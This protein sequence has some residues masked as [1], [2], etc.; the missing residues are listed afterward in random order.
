MFY[1]ISA[2]LLLFGILILYMAVM[3]VGEPNLELLGVMTEQELLVK[4]ADL[5]TAMKSDEGTSAFSM[6][7]IRKTIERAYKNLCDK[8]PEKLF[9][10]ERWIFDNY[11]KLNEVMTEQKKLMTRYNKLI[12]YKN[13]P[14]IYCLASLIVKGSGGAVSDKLIGRCIDT[15][16]EILPL[17]YEETELLPSAFALALL[18]YV[19]IFCGRSLFISD[20]IKAGIS[21]VASDRIDF[22]EL[23]F[24]SY[25]YVFIR[26]ADGKLMER[27][28]S[29]CLKNGLSAYERADNFLSACARYAGAVGSA[30]RSV[31]A[32]SKLNEDFVLE[33]C[34]LNKFLSD[35]SEVVYRQCTTATKRVYLSR[36]AKKSRGKSEIA[37]A[38]DIV[39][40]AVKEKKDIAYYILP[41]ELGKF[42]LVVYICLIVGYTISNCVTVFMY[43]GEY[44]LLASIVFL[45]ISLNLVL[46]F[47]TGINVR[48][49]SRRFM[50]RI[51]LGGKERA[52]IVYTVLVFDKSELD[53]MIDKLK[54]I[55]FANSDEIFSYGLLI[56]LPASKVE[57]TKADVEL[58]DYAKS[59]FNELGERYNLFLRRKS[60]VSGE[61]KYQ[62]WEKKR[63]AILDLNNLILHGA[64]EPFEV[65]LGS[66]YNVKYVV[67][68]DS[69]TVINCAYEL[70]EIMEH[71]FNVDKAVVSLNVKS[72]PSAIRTPFAEVMCDS[73][74]LNNYTNFIADANYDIFGSGNYT[75]KGIYR[76]SDFTEKVEDV[77]T[78]NRVLSHDFVEG[79]I[80]GCGASGESALDAYPETFSSYLQRNIR[81]LRGDY[82]LLPFLSPKIRDGKGRRRK[83]PVSVIGRMHILNNIILG[84]IPLS[85]ALLLL[86]S[87]FSARPLFLTPVAFSLNLFMLLG[88][89]RLL[90][91]HPKRVWY[92]CMRQFLMAS[93]LPVIAYNYTKAIIL[94]LYRLVVKKNLLDWRVFAHS[95]GRVS[96]LPNVIA[97]AAY[98]C[99][100]IFRFKWTFVVM[101]LLFM[102]GIIY[103]SYLSKPQDR[104][105][106]LTNGQ[107]SM[108]KKIAADTYIY[109]A[110]QLNK[111]NNYLPYDNYQLYGN[112]GYAKRTSPT[113]IAFMIVSLVSAFD[114]GFIERDELENYADKIL[115]SIERAEK[116]R[117]NL[118]NWMDVYTL[119]RLGGYVSSVDSGNLLAALLLL[120][121]VTSERI[122]RRANKLIEATD[123][124]AFFDCEKGLIAIGYNSDAK[125]YDNNQYDLLGS[126]A[127]LTYLVGI[128][129]G[130][131]EST[132]LRNLSS[133]CVRYKGTCLYSWTGGAFEYMMP[134]IFFEYYRGGLMHMSALN[135]LKANKAYA[136]KNGLPFWGVSE[137]QYAAF[138]D[139]GNYQYKAFGVP[140]IA[141]SNER[142]KAV[143]SPYASMLFL[144]FAPYEVA[145]NVE[146]LLGCGLK[147][148]AGLFEAYDD[149]VIKSYMAHHQG[150]ILASL[151][152][153]FCG[154]ELIKQF[155]SPDM[156]AAS[157]LITMSDVPK[158][159]KKVEYEY[160]EEEER[161]VEA[162]HTSPPTVNL[163]T[164][165]KYSVLIDDNGG[166]YSIYNGKYISRHYNHSGGMRLLLSYDNER[167]DLSRNGRFFDGRSE[168]HYADSKCSITQ[169]A[170]VLP[171]MDGEARC[172]RIKNLTLQPLSLSVESY[173]EVALAPLYDDISHKTF[174]GMFIQTSLS[175]RLGV[176][177]RRGKLIVAHFFDC[178]AEHQSNRSC[179]FGR[180]DGAEFGRVL[181]PIVSGKASLTLAPAEERVIK[182]YVLVGEDIDL[183]VRKAGLV[184]LEG[185]FDRSVSGCK[186]ICLGYGVGDK[187][188]KVASRLLYPAPN[189]YSGE[190]PLVCI[191]CSVVTER[192]RRKLKLLSRLAMFGINVHVVIVYTGDGFIKERITEEVAP[193]LGPNCRLSFADGEHSAL[194]EAS[195][196]NIDEIS[197]EPLGEHEVTS[198]MRGSV[199]L[200]ELR[201]AYK[202]GIGGFLSD[203]SFALSHHGDLPP[204]P[205]SNI[206]CSGKFGTI[207]TESGGGYVFAEN[208]R[209]NKL[210]EW[211]NDPVGDPCSDGVVLFE[212]GS[213]WSVSYNPVRAEGEY[214]VIHGFGYSEFRSGANGFVSTLIEYVYDNTK[215]Y[216]L[217][218]L[219][220]E[221]YERKVDA[222]LFTVPVLGD[223]RFKTEHNISCKFDGRLIVENLFD[224]S[225]FY[226]GCDRPI[227]NYV[228]HKQAYINKNGKYFAPK[229]DEGHEVAPAVVTSLVVPPRGVVKVRFYLSADG[230]VSR[231]GTDELIEQIKN[232]YE[233]LSCI[234]LKTGNEKIDYLAKWLP[235][236]VQCSRFLGRT[237]FY[238]AGG[239]I[240]F[241]DQ[242]QDCLT[243]LYVD[244][245]L[246]KRHIIECA[247]HQFEKGDVQH[248]WHPPRTGVRTLIS[249]DRL[250]LPYITAEYIE[251]TGD[252]AI[253]NE[254]APYLSDVKLLGKDWYGSPDVTVGT[255]TIREHCLKAIRA[256]AKL[257]ENGLA[258]MGGGDWND[259]MDKV[260][261]LGKG[262][263][264]WGSMF[265]YLT[266]K[267]FL[268]Y[269]KN[270]PP[271]YELMGKL[272][273]AIDGAWDGEWF[274]RAYCD[275]GTALG[276]KNSPECNIDLITQSFSALCG[277]VDPKKVKTALYSAARLLVDTENGIIKLLDP[278]LK[279]MKV[280]YICD[281]PPG[282]RENGGQ[283]T[284]GAVWFIMSLFSVGE[285]DYAYKLLDMISP[286]THSLTKERTLRY[287]VEPYVISADVYSEPSG[288]GG[289]SWYTG[290]ASWYYYVL[291][292]Y[293]FGV[294]ICGDMLTVSP[295]LPRS[296]KSASIEL[297]HGEVSFTVN[298]D[299][300]EDCGE[301][302][303]SL[304]RH[305]YA[306][307]S[308][309]ITEGLNKKELLLRR[310]KR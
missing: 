172:V 129:L 211:S 303:I 92:E 106:K 108:L 100:A 202:L 102:T 250:F 219:S 125:A 201:Y 90:F 28:N 158:A 34:P 39:K 74:G 199:E 182:T 263:S 52:M 242:L 244:P 238:Q 141:L 173:M 171:N 47:I 272:K 200:P 285:A 157:L 109:F 251:F 76:V 64:S 191:K 265:L 87:A 248:W 261:V 276:S 83:N 192:I 19:A 9:D 260:G 6:R 12:G 147:G 224:K 229:T 3:P 253:L 150:M 268:P 297:R 113:D 135:V 233:N 57:R 204:R 78:D 188:R 203:C 292:R 306:S 61:D 112:V 259:A 136:K 40:R 114:L 245:S 22:A 142:R 59:R 4:I 96:F 195:A 163:M 270:K 81:W 13:M 103:A 301:W 63:G 138:D 89:L 140:E 41:K 217:T 2:L 222:M 267:K 205:W 236:Q 134:S 300:G 99:L 194:V 186:Q 175:D 156:K 104:Q 269:V 117:G 252:E 88:T 295:S 149:G 287:E 7:L 277:C 107:E 54:T 304:G 18:E 280:G 178:E 75:G 193:L 29:I 93:C 139:M 65:V 167:I 309:A 154:G 228:C 133:R 51:R 23:R 36:I 282:V 24:N 97:S 144:P 111:S 159:R 169:I 132:S 55:A 85:S 16:N 53:E 231:R 50:P 71:P 95:K 286:I 180:S 38:S 119:N 44:K 146:K 234:K 279:K 273:D 215:Y 15:F 294:K 254:R 288:K 197:F 91:F 151:C 168:F 235:Y 105:K 26:H 209:Q 121:N 284:H 177:A 223:F 258:L 67:T 82:Q 42:A 77:F 170:A 80:A 130:K 266:V 198:V 160:I 69:D 290:A 257:G 101:A 98:V 212:E 155:A 307:D 126:E 293:L 207:I 264:V 225:L 189:L 32:L 33:H 218:L 58:I 56:D 164:N 289:W 208:S 86:I 137:S 5:A 249:D 196:T 226:M 122:S 165:G 308:I 213:A 179:F 11:Y 66:S 35:R 281:Y 8:P 1:F 48:I 262:T 124:G 68:L 183:L 296:I 181:D 174:S 190:L 153:Y 240:G 94:T 49:F 230:R 120:R 214:Q 84:L 185:F 31:Y 247:S 116:W 299:N 232:K 220:K 256:S 291:V 161:F 62:G 37:Y 73:V 110:R 310:V 46:M 162:K 72:A 184:R 302:Q 20:K 27:I 246:V 305:S 45:P 216:E 143:A 25:V 145:K 283:Y 152:N 239:A 14:R 243:M 128:G 123:I 148:E 127:M 115:F 166:G 298:I 118:Y 241:R 131:I 206:I 210:T 79:A 255:G 70:V 17:R 237:G 21:D 176:V 275:D 221:N 271:L 274:T 227:S 43:A 30:V 10:F 60:K 187:M 278:P